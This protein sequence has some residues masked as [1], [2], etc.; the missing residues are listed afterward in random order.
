MGEC[1]IIQGW[2]YVAAYFP[3]SKQS[4]FQ[5]PSICDSSN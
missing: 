2:I 3:T 5:E 1:S 4:H